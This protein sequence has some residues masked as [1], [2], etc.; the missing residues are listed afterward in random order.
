MATNELIFKDLAEQIVSGSFGNLLVEERER[1][2]VAIGKA[3]DFYYGYQEQYIKQYR[4]EEDRDFLDKDKPTFNYTRAI[5]NEYVRGVM[6]KPITITFA[7]D[8]NEGVWKEIATPLTTF[9]VIPFFKTVQRIAEISDTCFVMTRYDK[10]RRITYFEE[11]RGEFVTFLPDDTNPR[12]IGSVV[13][14]YLYDTGSGN[15][16]SRLMRRIE[17]WNRDKWAVWLYSPKLKRLQQ[18]GGAVNPYGFIPGVRFQPLQDDNTFYGISGVGDIVAIN[19][20]Y[21][22]LWTSLIRIATFQS[23]SI[24]VVTTDG[25]MDVIV[26]PTRFIKF[27]KAKEG[28]KSSDAKYITPSAKIDEVKKT[29]LSLK[30]ELQNFTHVPAEVLS[31]AGSTSAPQS[32]YALRIKRMPIENLWQERRESYGPSLRRLVQMAVTVQKVNGG[33]VGPKDAPAMMKEIKPTITFSDTK[34]GLAP[35]E[36]IIK[37]EH[38]LKYGLISPLDLV[39]REHPEM[40]R[41]EAKEFIK[42]NREELAEL[43]M[44]VMEGGA[45][46]ESEYKRLKAAVEPKYEDEVVGES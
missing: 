11:I 45:T 18:I 36:Q 4:G 26:A 14:N 34:P 2:I 38:E 41:D 5:I 9:E 30:D 24:L 35:Q 31:S 12:E 17:I 46:A 29:L 16:E 10:A 13:I 37:D 25:Q 39:I 28:T 20:V 43:G 3:W 33:D 42:K 40:T 23:F 15:P 32:G 6:G 8:G 1:E 22:N 44:G 7:N 21:N 27:E 19:E